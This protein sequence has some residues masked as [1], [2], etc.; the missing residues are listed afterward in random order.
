LI[1]SAYHWQPEAALRIAIILAENSVLGLPSGLQV[2]FEMVTKDMSAN[3]KLAKSLLCNILMPICSRGESAICMNLLERADVK[4]ELDE[5]A[6]DLHLSASTIAPITSRKEW[7]DGIKNNTPAVPREGNDF[8]GNSSAVEN[9]EFTIPSRTLELNSG[10]RVPE[11]DVF[12]QSKTV[13]GFIALIKQQKRDSYSRW[14]EWFC[15]WLPSLSFDDISQVQNELSSLHD[16]FSLQVLCLEKMSEKIVSTR[17]FDAAH[18]LFQEQDKYF[19]MLG[20]THRYRAAKLMVRLDSQKAYPLIFEAMVDNMRF[21]HG[22]AKSFATQLDNLQELVA[23]RISSQEIWNRIESYLLPTLNFFASAADVPLH[24]ENRTLSSNGSLVELLE[25]CLDHPV[26]ILSAGCMKSLC[27]ILEDDI[28]EFHEKLKRWLSSENDRFIRPCLVVLQGMRSVPESLLQFLINDLRSLTH[29]CDFDIRT[30]AI[31]ILKKNNAS[32]PPPFPQNDH[33]LELYIHRPLY[34]PKIHLT[35]RSRVS[36]TSCLEDTF[37]PRE[38]IRIYEPH[39]QCLSHCT[40][41]PMENLLERTLQIMRDLED[42]SKWNKNAEM[43]FREKCENMEINFTFRRLRTYILQRAI[44]HLAGELLDS[45]KLSQRNAQNV[46]ILFCTEDHDA[47]RVEPVVRPKFIELPKFPQW[48]DRTSWLK[49]KLTP[50]E[51]DSLFVRR[52]DD[53]LVLAEHTIWSVGTSLEEQRISTLVP[54][55]ILPSV[56]ASEKPFADV[57]KVHYEDYR[58][59]IQKSVAPL[60]VM[61]N[62]A[63]DTRFFASNWLAL[64]SEIAQN[65]GLKFVTDDGLFCWKFDNEIVAK[66]VY[67]MDGHPNFRPRFS[68]DCPLGLGWLVLVK[69][70]LL[71]E[72]S[73]TFGELARF[74]SFT[75]CTDPHDG[76]VN[77]DNAFSEVFVEQS[78]C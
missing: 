72:F 39:V 25:F 22:R 34:D 63:F 20:S 18:K 11:K 6:S 10:A 40:N 48:D 62:F 29:S 50:H 69:K 60:L 35:D 12:S 68:H 38:I 77:T 30:R 49:F 23:P 37:D 31:E 76:A 55:K 54:S 52:I 7:L 61:E 33:L 53:W 32:V 27:D 13:D 73:R 64:N 47:V 56:N 58:K 78:L 28:P 57:K 5:F 2:Y 67:W 75:R 16:H 74:H 46:Y 44:L 59:G 1:E 66:S 71:K 42:E 51:K 9:E 15:S 17:L 24:E 26:N 45:G 4:D 14:E 41:I 3:P 19:D 8:E 36:S 70:R 43:R 65:F 21:D